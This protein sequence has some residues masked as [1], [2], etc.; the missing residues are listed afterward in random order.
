MV[1]RAVVTVENKQFCMY[2]FTDEARARES[3]AY[4]E[5]RRN[6]DEEL[7]SKVA[8]LPESVALAFGR[9]APEDGDAG[10]KFNRNSFA[11]HEARTSSVMLTASMLNHAC[12]RNASQQSMELRKPGGYAT[13][14]Y[15]NCDIAA[16]EEITIS[17][18]ETYPLA[19]ERRA[20]LRRTYGFECTCPAC[21]R[22]DV[23]AQLEN[24]SNL[25]REFYGATKVIQLQMR[26]LG[27][28]LSSDKERMEQVR[29]CITLRQEFLHVL[30]ACNS[31]P[32]QCGF[33]CQ[34][35]STLMMIARSK[36]WVAEA[37]G[38]LREKRAFEALTYGAFEHG[39]YS[40]VD[41][42]LAQLGATST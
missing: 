19:P 20:H 2:G 34:G 41:K 13:R 10:D 17:Y 7:A 8:A 21:V 11:G 32:A 28:V 12:W 3:A 25:Y 6:A 27:V 16:G 24:R 31:D 36:N 9:L 14:I 1:E 23:G 18:V 42:Q 30:Q 15:T 5:F 26:Q 35:L 39:D 4:K 40:E 38:Y 37:S 29:K 33:V 22:P